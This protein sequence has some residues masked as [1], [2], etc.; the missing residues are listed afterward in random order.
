MA[1]REP[2]TGP[3]RPGP[4]Q[5]ARRP[6]AVRHGAAFPLP[7]PQ[8]VFL[9]AGGV[10]IG[11]Q[12]LG[13]ADTGEHR[14]PVRFGP[15]FPVPARRIRVG[16]AAAAGKGRSARACRLG[17]QRGRRGA[18]RRWPR[19]RLRARLPAGVHRADH[20]RTRHAAADPARTTCCPGRS[21]VSSSPPARSGNSCRSW[22][23]RS[24]SAPSAVRG[25]DHR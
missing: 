7:G 18:D 23:S 4:R 11:P 3:V 1:D 14:T 9:I 17:D 19:G 20:H 8:V 24:C 2:S 21:G 13:L 6:H 16:S 22:R 5:S 12:V 25:A 15:G 10:L